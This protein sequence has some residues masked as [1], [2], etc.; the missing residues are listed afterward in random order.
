MENPLKNQFGQF[1]QY[2]IQKVK[3]LIKEEPLSSNLLTRYKNY[4]VFKEV[5]GSGTFSK[6]YLGRDQKTQTKVA[7]KEVS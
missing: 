3:K 6:V 5:L 7:V 1:N 4:I 2:K